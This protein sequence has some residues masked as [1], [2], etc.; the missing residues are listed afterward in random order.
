[1]IL[2]L[3][4]GMLLIVP[5]LLTAHKI[6]RRIFIRSRIKLQLMTG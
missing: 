5:F 6:F 3:C 1:M 4:N 2:A